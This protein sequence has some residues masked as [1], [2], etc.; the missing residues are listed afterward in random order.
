MRACVGWWFGNRPGRVPMYL[1]CPGRETLLPKQ[2][3]RAAQV[4]QIINWEKYIW[5]YERNIERI[6]FK[7]WEKGVCLSRVNLSP[8]QMSQMPR[9]KLSNQMKSWEKYNWLNE[10]N[11]FDKL[12]EITVDRLREIC[13]PGARELLPKRTRRTG[14]PAFQDAHLTGCRARTIQYH[15]ISWDLALLCHT[16]LCYT[17][18]KSMIHMSD[19]P[20]RVLLV[21]KTM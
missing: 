3:S 18:H 19:I 12:K 9:Q 17:A 20:R 7:N 8:K 1:V 2:T 6:A 16:K 10:R 5:Q 14:T 11:T 13:M 15:I 4:S 21:D